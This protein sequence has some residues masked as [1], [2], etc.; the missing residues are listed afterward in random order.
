MIYQFR[1]LV[2]TSLFANILYDHC[3]HDRRLCIREMLMNGEMAYFQKC[4][5]FAIFP[6]IFTINWVMSEAQ[7]VPIEYTFCFI[8]SEN[9]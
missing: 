1:D 4:V 6:Y 5:F 2:P 8:C 9:V 7:Y 3:L